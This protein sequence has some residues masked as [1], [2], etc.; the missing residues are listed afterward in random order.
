MQQSRLA[1][2]KI[3]ERGIASQVTITSTQVNTESS[4]ST[5]AR[6]NSEC[7][8]VSAVHWVDCMKFWLA[9]TL[10]KDPPRAVTSFQ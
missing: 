7:I 2:W 1:D 3:K 9:V 10:P 4:K 8:E 6:I 5:D